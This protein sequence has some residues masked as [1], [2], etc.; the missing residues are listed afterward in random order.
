MQLIGNSR[1]VCCCSFW[2]FLILCC[3]STIINWFWVF[4]RWRRWWFNWWVA[5]TTIVWASWPR[6]APGAR[7]SPV[8]VAT[9]IIIPIIVAIVIIPSISIVAEIPV[10]KST[11]EAIA[12]KEHYMWYLLSTF[13]VETGQNWNEF[14]PKKNHS[15]IPLI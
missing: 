8:A 11:I 6:I 10:L 2:M 4:L 1:I 3:C 7:R 5:I 14:F 9:T 12:W 15:Q 13:Y